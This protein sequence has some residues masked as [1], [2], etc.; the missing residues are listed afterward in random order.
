MTFFAAWRDGWLAI[1][2]RQ[3]IAL[4]L[5]AA[6]VLLVNIRQPFPEIA[7]LHHVPTV[8]LILSAPWWLRRWPL[9]DGALIC[10]VLFFALH[11]I[12]A[13]W[14]Y[15]NMPYDQWATALT[16]HSLSEVMGWQR[17][18]IDR[19]V[20]FAC[21]AL[22]LPA[23]AVWL[24]RVLPISRKGLALAAITLIL[25]I[26]AAYELFEWLLALGMAPGA[27]EQ[28]NGQQGDMWD[29]QKDMALAF[30]GSIIAAPFWVRAKGVR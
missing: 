24:G 30:L 6:L 8:A 7:P 13:R 28:Y 4:A 16:G 14:T 25:A 20:H 15:T 17:N 10:A 21:G 11:S 12:A 3:R 9:S 19:L 1:P 27:A 26:S 29:A 23:M 5:L 18:H 22:L 2:M